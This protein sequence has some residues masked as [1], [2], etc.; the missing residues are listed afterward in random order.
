MSREETEGAGG[1]NRSGI[2]LERK[3][4]E[5][6]ARARRGGQSVVLLASG[7]RIDVPFKGRVPGCGEVKSQTSVLGVENW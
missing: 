1:H 7:L 4:L 2:P 3:M 6:R 5:K